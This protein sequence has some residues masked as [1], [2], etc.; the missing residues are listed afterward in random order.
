MAVGCLF[1]FIPSLPE[2]ID[3]VRIKE[4]FTEENEILNDKV[5]GLYGSFYSFGAIIAPI[6]GGILR[7]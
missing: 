4:G 7:D 3:A 5:S 6:L 2:V 1:F